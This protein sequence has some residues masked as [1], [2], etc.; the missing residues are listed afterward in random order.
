MQVSGE[1]C[2]TDLRQIFSSFVTKHTNAC[3]P[4]YIEMVV[5]TSQVGKVAHRAGTLGPPSHSKTCKHSTTISYGALGTGRH[6]F[7]D[8]IFYL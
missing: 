4:M 5:S 7:W 2:C 3:A 8:T 1:K 6:N